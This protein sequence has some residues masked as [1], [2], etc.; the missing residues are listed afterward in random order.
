M[1]W[2]K[3]VLGIRSPTVSAT[4]GTYGADGPRPGS[5]STPYEVTRRGGSSDD[6]P[7]DETFIDPVDYDPDTVP[8]EQELRMRNR[9][10]GHF[11]QY[12]HQAEHELTL[13]EV[14]RALMG[15]Q[16]GY[17]IRIVDDVFR[18][19]DIANLRAVRVD[20]FIDRYIEKLKEMKAWW[21]VA[22]NACINTQ[23][24]FDDNEAKMTRHQAEHYNEYGI[25][26]DS[27]LTVELLEAQN[28]PMYKVPR[29]LPPAPPAPPMPGYPPVPPPEPRAPLL[30]FYMNCAHQHVTCEA[31]QPAPHII[32]DETFTFDIS[33][34]EEVLVCTLV[35]GDPA[36]PSDSESI[37]ECQI[38]L[39][40]IQDQ[41]KVEMRCDL[42]DGATLQLAVQ[43]IWSKARLYENYRMVFGEKLMRRK[44]ELETAERNLYAGL[45]PVDDPVSNPASYAVSRGIDVAMGWMKLHDA[46]RLSRWFVVI[47][48]LLSALAA[49]AKPDFLNLLVAAF[50]FY[51][52]LSPERWTPASYTYMLQAIAFSYFMD[53]MWAW[54]YFAAWGLNGDVVFHSIAKVMTVMQFIFKIILFVF[55]WKC[56]FDLRELQLRQQK[57][58]EVRGGQ[59]EPFDLRRAHRMA[60]EGPKQSTSPF[61]FLGF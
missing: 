49:F 26:D 38:D 14:T 21:E 44:A 23:R 47:Y 50:S 35:C 27:R 11:K 58:M 51:N 53:I 52:N 61:K 39:K 3:G 37:G 20:V 17:D 42:G 55:F 60:E 34:P 30:W 46:Q 7:E 56:K 48:M 16:R 40:D 41:R 10:L 9:I 43:W 12:R 4:K 29:V 18:R 31:L 13:N 5:S 33:Q 1:Q 28:I 54:T 36:I 45:T 19:A 15:V 6:D 24:M 32:I 25:S 59:T 8:A 57:R 22:R 2:I